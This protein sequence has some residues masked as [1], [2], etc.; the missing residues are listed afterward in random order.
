[1]RPFYDKIFIFLNT[2]IISLYQR[3]HYNIDILTI[4]RQKMSAQ[5]IGIP[6]EGFAEFCRKAAAEGAVL[7]KNDGQCLPLQE[8]ETVSVFGRTQINYYRSGT[9]SGGSV[10]VEYTTNLLNGLR[11]KSRIK[12]NEELAAIYEGW[13]G[14]N[15][16][17]NG[18]GGWAA[19]PWNQKE[20]PLTDAIVINA[21]KR[22]G[23]AIVVLG[24]T[25]GEDK[26]NV[27]APGSYLPTAGE[28][29][30]LRLVCEH[31]EQVAMVL[32][33]ANI[34]DMNWILDSSFAARI[35]SVLY[36]WQG[37]MEGGN[38]AAD[39]L[40][41]DTAPGGK[42]PD[43]IARSIED[44]PSYANYGDTIR[45][46]YQE[47]IYVGYRYF[48]TFC[49]EK[50]RFEFGFGM[51]YTDFSIAAEDAR[52]VEKDGQTCFLLRCTVK[53]TG[54]T[55]CGREVVQVYYEAPQGKLGKPAKVLAAF[56]KTRLLEPGESQRLD[57]TFPV[58]LMAS[59]DDGGITGNPSCYVLEEGEYFLY[60]GNSVKNNK[61]INVEGQNSYRIEV[62][63]VVER[64]EQALAP[65]ERFSRL[66]PGR[67][68]T[69]GAYET[70][71][72]YVPTRKVSMAERVMGNLPA[73]IPQTG[74]LGYKL[75]DVYDKRI[76]M[77]AFVAQLTDEELATLAR[78]EGMC[79]PRV[80]PGTA[81]AFGGLSG[82]LFGYGIPVACTADGPSGIRMDSGL[83]STQLPIGTLI[84]A[85]WDPDM[86][87]EL[88]TLEG[89][90]LS[91]NN[92]DLLLGPGINI[93]RYPLNGRNF[94]YYSE[95]P[96]LSGSFAA[97][98]VRGIRKGGSNATLKHFA[99][100]NQE[101][102]R[103]R[104]DAAVS[105][106]AL[107]EIYLKSFEM[108]VKQ[109]GA[110][111]VMTSYNPVNGY[112]TASSYDLNTTILRGQ[113]GFRGIVMT[114]WWAK[115]N[116]VILG[117]AEDK[118]YS[119]HMLRSQNDLYMVVPNYGA[120]LNS[121]EDNTLES[122]KN[123]TLTRG[124][125]QRSAMNICNFLMQAPAFFRKQEGG[126][127]VRRFEANRSLSP[128]TSQDLSQDARFRPASNIT[129]VL[130]V[131]GG[132]CYNIIARIMSPLTN[133]YQTACNITLNGHLAATM[134]TNGTSGKW[135]LQM[136]VKV[137]LEKG[138]YEI[139]LE[140]VKPGMEVDWIEFKPVS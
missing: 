109:G 42:L 53:N 83:K 84:A 20:M 28:T 105:E 94:E 140:H 128:D 96:L 95:D 6:L 21:R 12:V 138:L 139:K 36:V 10:N 70:E 99:C 51:S 65:V 40:T 30:M 24:R 35:K 63:R 64:L 74:N 2:I 56:K 52:I 58:G 55:H 107:R 118:K 15:P 18:G 13:V 125:L 115:M 31:F 25:A 111:A 122:L 130:K 34:I 75:R 126:V 17:D 69:D 16:F 87:E 77:E 54:K 81:S 1:M 90:E 76:G 37:G 89:K 68:K 114:D 98:T 136:L 117:G 121:S 127:T 38:A 120:E 50:V 5:N 100:N 9:G 119:N 61:R 27:N 110:N 72:E 26:D 133:M 103:H 134:Q 112:W 101:L 57:I 29:D 23:K 137:E 14:R 85:T 48:E 60:L 44:Y 123:G 66:K 102:S 8:G 32:N 113:W 106:R 46:Y 82:S 39:V 78:G 97:A 11:S 62:L 93:H 131:C 41:G 108:A 19:E 104:V 47:D 116:D 132:G 88:F 4:R 71:Y 59:Y 92:I 129:A 49:P 7:L 73:E 43:T 135:I 3:F 33:V 79:S 45:N 91:E 80:T 22:S 67:R 86:V 124:E